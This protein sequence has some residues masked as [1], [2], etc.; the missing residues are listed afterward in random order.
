VKEACLN[1]LIDQKVHI[2]ELTLGFLLTYGACCFAGIY[3]TR[4]VTTAER[5]RLLKITTKAARIAS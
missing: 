1:L 5:K 3:S 4:R 2:F